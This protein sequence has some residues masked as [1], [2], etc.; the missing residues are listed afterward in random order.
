MANEIDAFRGQLSNELLLRLSSLLASSVDVEAS[1]PKP[2]PYF[3]YV[4]DISYGS[5]N[6]LEA[7]AWVAGA[8]IDFGGGGKAL[9][10]ND[11]DSFPGGTVKLGHLSGSL[12]GAAESMTQISSLGT[13]TGTTTG[14]PVAAP[15]S[16]EDLGGTALP[17]GSVLQMDTSN[18]D[19]EVILP[20]AGNGFAGLSYVVRSVG[21]G[22][23]IVSSSAAG[24]TVDG[25]ATYDVLS[26]KT[27]TLVADG[28]LGP[29]GI[30][31]YLI[32]SLV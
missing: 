19:I 11:A 2:Q 6:A 5:S 10:L 30:G 18:G 22:K 27:V 32:T 28:A 23:V 31:N 15:L 8:E 7:P 13:R 14:T 12:P 1:V 9:V 4:Y 26:D 16:F 21:A 17:P 25:G 3:G 20:P 29:S 24:E